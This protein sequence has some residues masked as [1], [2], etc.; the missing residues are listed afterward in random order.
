MENCPVVEKIKI[1]TLR[2][3]DRT[4]RDSPVNLQAPGSTYF[5]ESLPIL[6]FG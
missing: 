1:S 2:R 3:A 4:Q 6:R 5:S